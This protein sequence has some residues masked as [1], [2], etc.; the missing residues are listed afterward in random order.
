VAM[1][2]L[3]RTDGNGPVGAASRRFAPGDAENA[4]ALK[5]ASDQRDIRRVVQAERAGRACMAGQGGTPGDGTGEGDEEGAGDML[6][7]RTRKGRLR[8]RSARI[9]PWCSLVVARDGGRAGD[10]EGVGKS[11]AREVGARAQTRDDADLK[12][13]DCDARRGQV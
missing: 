12:R 2:V 8:Q 6:R 5:N 1:G 10:R 3:N 4:L 9:A 11:K 7:R 13:H